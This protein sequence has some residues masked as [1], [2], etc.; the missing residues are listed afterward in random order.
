MEIDKEKTCAKFEQKTLNSMVI[1]TRRVFNFLGKS[2]FRALSKV[3]CG[4]LHYLISII[5]L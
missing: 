4:I 5:I 2:A 3:L 1:E